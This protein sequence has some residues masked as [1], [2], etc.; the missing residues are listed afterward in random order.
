MRR[1]ASTFLVGICGLCWTLSWTLPAAAEIFVLNSGGRVVGELLNPTE[2][3]RQRFLVR[4]PAGSRLMFTPEQVK[5]VLYVRPEETEYETICPSYG[6]TVD[7][8]WAL[9]EWC[10]EHQLTDQR[11]KHLERIIELDTDHAQARRALGYSQV[12]GRW[13]TQDQVMI[14][15]GYQRY[16]GRWRTS[17][18]IELLENK[19][20]IDAA[21]KDWAQKI[22]RWRAWLA[23]DRAPEARKNFAE[24]RDPYAV[25]A[26]ARNLQSEE[27]PAIRILY[28]GVLARI[29]SPAAE[30]AL[31]VASIE[32]PVE[33]VRLTSL[34]FLEKAN[35]PTLTSF[36]V[37][38]L[39]SK[40][41]RVV[42]LAGI[43]LGRLKDPS[44][45]NPLIEALV[46][47][48]KYKIVKPGGDGAMSFGAGSSG[49]SGFSAGGGP[50]FIRKQLA[51][52]T[53]L[54]ALIVITGQNF[55]FDKQAWRAWASSQ[56][57]R[58]DLDARR[59]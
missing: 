52:Q 37:G 54:D 12:G 53:V 21:E 56:R 59:G 45:I 6:D 32:D 2:N 46:T 11:E 40:D 49:G 8:Q 14:E 18:E 38:K 33:E 48:H 35:D 15:R 17:Q 57:K 20:K 3:P 34:D 51:N 10:R 50:K 27:I 55:N 4:T 44:S 29:G 25:E 26:L 22:K 1:F 58:P 43:A 30:E 7:D 13:M 28:I 5:Q 24:V 39:K 16:K 19:R 23:G 41:N 47:T 42:N 31:A 9:A 36:Y